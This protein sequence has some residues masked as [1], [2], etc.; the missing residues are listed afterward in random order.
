MNKKALIL[1]LPMI[2]AVFFLGGWLVLRLQ[3]TVQNTE[4]Q[5]VSVSEQPIQEQTVGESQLED[6]I[7]QAREMQLP[8]IDTIGWQEH[9]DERLGVQFMYPKGWKVKTYGEDAAFYG[10]I[11]IGNRKFS[12]VLIEGESECIVQFNK[13]K[14][15]KDKLVEEIKKNYES[16]QFSS[17]KSLQLSHLA[18]YVKDGLS[19]HTYFVG[20]NSIQEISLQQ[21]VSVGSGDKEI[22]QVFYGIL[23]TLK[24][25][26]DSVSSC[27]AVGSGE[28]ARAWKVYT[29]NTSNFS[30]KYPNDWKYKEGTFV[31]STGSS[32]KT[33]S[34][35]K[36]D[37]KC[38]IEASPA[39]CGVT[40]SISPI[41]SNENSR[42]EK[43]LKILEKANMATAPILMQKI[44]SSNLNITEITDY[45]RHEFVF[46]YNG[47][48]YSLGSENFGSDEANKEFWN[49]LDTMV[50]T[51][52]VQ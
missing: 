46:D 26:Q 40:V 48:S 9:K 4:K 47:Y 3:K 36:P 27:K 39:L 44:C 6:L 21:F 16:T 49:A 17:V 19:T 29:D 15:P 12:N 7:A 14:Y 5:E 28:G 34:F 35:Y 43:Y 1:S 33:V 20:G 41:K 24:P 2:L 22:E 31:D 50:E 30:L 13:T 23:S 10:K 51:L 42:N 38:S 45:L 18:L 52:S 8:K 37:M 32:V 11:C 25:I